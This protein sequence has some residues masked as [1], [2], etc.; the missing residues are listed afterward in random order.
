MYSELSGEAVLIQ[1]SFEH[2]GQLEL[3]VY[4]AFYDVLDY[5]IYNSR[6]SL[7]T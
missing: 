4:Y 3:S 6:Q 7:L 2:G 5:A 1:T